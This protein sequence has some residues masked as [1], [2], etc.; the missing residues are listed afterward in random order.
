MNR[1][2]IKLVEEWKTDG[3]PKQE[4]FDWTSSKTNW[5]KAFPNESNFISKL[6]EV[7]DREAVRQICQAKKYN[8]R[9]KFLSVMI[10]GYGD[11]GYGPYRV[12]QMLI[13]DHAEDVLTK[14]FK[15]CQNSDPKSAY[16]FLRKNRIRI[17]GPSYTTKF[18][19]FCTP[20]TVGAPIYDSYISLWIEAFASKE[21]A[22]VRITSEVWNSKTYAHYWDWIKE[23]SNVLNCYPDDIEFVLF[24]DSEVKFSRN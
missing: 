9:E 21:F 3:S 5:I 8:I 16:D 22:D 14:A 10:W 1:R 15:I 23:H 18:L 4:G 11:R 2:L 7:I 17:L 6:P 12:T 24:R 19:T 20:R 13:Q